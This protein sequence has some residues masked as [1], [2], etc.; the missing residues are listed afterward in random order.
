MAKYLSNVINTQQQ[1]NITGS[2][3]LRQT[4]VEAAY[5][6]DVAARYDAESVA[7]VPEP[8]VA[9]AVTK[10][11]EKVSLVN[12]A[13]NFLSGGKDSLNFDV[14]AL[15][16]PSTTAIQSGSSYVAKETEELRKLREAGWKPWYGTV[17]RDI[18][19]YNPDL[20]AYYGEDDSNPE[21]TGA[22][23]GGGTTGTFL[24]NPDDPYKMYKVSG[25]NYPYRTYDKDRFDTYWHNEY[26]TKFPTNYTLDMYAEQH[27][28]PNRKG[29]SLLGSLFKG[30]TTAVVSTLTGYALSPII[31]PTMAGAAGGAVGG[32]PAAVQS[33]SFVPL[34][35]GAALGAVGGAGASGALGKAGK[36][37]VG[38]LEVGG[39][40]NK[41]FNLF[42]N[43][44][45]SDAMVSL[46]DTSD[47]EPAYSSG[48]VINPSLNAA[49][50]TRK[51]V[52]D[53]FDTDPIGT[54]LASADSSMSDIFRKR[55]RGSFIYG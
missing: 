39:I 15:R 45:S 55:K 46:N 49:V 36:A 11:Y 22:P 13:E 32:A 33:K 52:A 42:N 7:A 54:I 37:A 34:L 53:G 23:Y 48:K 41:L 26:S 10:D 5:N 16:N 51:R 17:Y 50:A 28:N 24:V 18:V 6:A 14:A 43:G 30:L 29:D 47:N 27:P 25:Q 12:L 8:E 9:A 21:A 4:Q 35:A 1:K 40:A 44:V 2:S 20:F 38:A 3:P 31:G 19:N